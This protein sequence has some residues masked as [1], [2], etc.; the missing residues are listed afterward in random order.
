MCIT[1]SHMLRAL[2][3]CILYFKYQYKETLLNFIIKLL[4]LFIIIII[5]LFISISI[6]LLFCIVA[7]PNR[8]R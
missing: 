3:E 4:L 1:Y 2:K 7:N 6:I 8:I 5:V